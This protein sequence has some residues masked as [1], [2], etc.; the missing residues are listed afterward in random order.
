M[1]TRCRFTRWLAAVAVG[2]ASLATLQANYFRTVVIDPRHG[3]HDKGG[4]WGLVYEK[5]LCLD[6]ACR[7]EAYLRARGV[8][9]VMTRNSDYFVSLPERVAIANRYSSAIFVAIHYNYTWKR[10]ISGLET[11][12]NT[13]QSQSLGAYVQDG[14]L[15]RVSA[16]NRNAKYAR[17]YVIRNATC[18]AIL[19]ECGFVSNDSERERM[20]RAWYRQAI[21]EGIGQGIMRYRSN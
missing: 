18:P 6:T 11:F 4:Q 12:Y 9:T 21:A 8:R 13:P 17:Y 1:K 14:I 10:E 20:K 16:V 7:L 3:G 5:H 15:H 2:V 19:V